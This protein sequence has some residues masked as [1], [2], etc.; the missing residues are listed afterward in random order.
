MSLGR[1]VRFGRN[2]VKTGCVNIGDHTSIWHN[3]ILRGDVAPITIG[4]RCNI[5]DNTVL[6]GSLNKWETIIG[7]DVSVGH[8]CILHG[9]ELSDECF[10]GMGS[11][12]MNGS[13]IGGR[14]VVAAGSLISQ[15]SVFKEPNTLVMGRPGKVVR[16]LKPD[17]IEMVLNTPRG[18]MKYAQ[19]WLPSTEK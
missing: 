14:V 16:E 5:Q 8:L 1:D 15:G 13:Y 18:Y 2:V 11:I 4:Q 6:H 3:V 7:N 17:E 12:I 19:Q 9:C 10:I